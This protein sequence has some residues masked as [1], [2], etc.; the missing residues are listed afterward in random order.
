[1]KK[2]I[3][4]MWANGIGQDITT[5][6][7]GVGEI[8]ARLSEPLMRYSTVYL[9]LATALPIIHYD[10]LYNGCIGI[11]VSTPEF[12]LVGALAIAENA[13]KSGN[14]KWG[15]I[16]FLVCALLSIIM[17]ATLVD[18]FI[19]SF[20]DIALKILNFSRCLTAVGFSIVLS[21][22]GQVQEEEPLNVQSGS[23]LMQIEQQVNQLSEQ[24]NLLVQQVQGMFNV[25][26][27][28]VQSLVQS[29]VAEQ[30]VNT[31]PSLNF[32][33]LASEADSLRLNQESEPI[34]PI[35]LNPISEPVPMV[36]QV[37]AEPTK[38]QLVK[39][40]H[41]EPAS[42]EPKQVQEEEPVNIRV[43]RFV[44]E[45]VQST[46]QVPKLDEIMNVCK[47]SKGSASQGRKEYQSA[48]SVV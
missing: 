40:V 1:M 38:V 45:Q 37:Q 11:V 46:G 31:E 17:I 5:I 39:K 44:H 42:I 26:R 29:F 21:K 8:L 41:L 35:P 2:R 15:V 13:V 6:F 43:K 30:R 3:P 23:N 48:L 9:A 18:I 47:C 25:Q 12:V 19:W 7:K 16:L 10:P 34:E 24:M 27:Q 20:P 4:Q 33:V 28:E 22:L 32:D 36:Q 14:K